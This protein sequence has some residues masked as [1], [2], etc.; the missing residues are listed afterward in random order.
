MFQIMTQE[1][2]IDVMESV[3]GHSDDAE[4]E[5][6]DYAKILVGYSIFFYIRSSKRKYLCFN[7]FS[8]YLTSFVSFRLYSQIHSSVLHST[9]FQYFVR[10]DIDVGL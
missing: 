8:D 1:G 6:D 10:S 5:R 7:A 3:M 9:L 2:W 4:D